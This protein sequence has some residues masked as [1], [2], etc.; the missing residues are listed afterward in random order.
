MNVFF[1]AET[2][3]FYPGEPYGDA[4]GK[5]CVELSLETYQTLMHE[6][7]QGKEIKIVDGRPKAFNS[8]VRPD[9]LIAFERD[10]RDSNIRNTEWLVARH[11]EEK[12]LELAPTLAVEQF[13][14]LLSYRQSLRDWPQT[15]SFPSAELRPIAP[16]W[17]AEQPQ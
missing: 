7:E 14:E 15:K 9:Q 13:S 3:G 1:C 12:D 6:I 8:V 5:E 17:I 16:F 4:V 11:R 2:G 10:W